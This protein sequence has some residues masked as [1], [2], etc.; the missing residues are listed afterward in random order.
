LLLKKK[1]DQSIADEIKRAA[2]NKA[3]NEQQHDPDDVSHL[4]SDKPSHIEE[5]NPK[6]M[7]DDYYEDADDN[8]ANEL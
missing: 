4:V 3:D 7:L 8:V 2:E 5:D 6:S 1:A